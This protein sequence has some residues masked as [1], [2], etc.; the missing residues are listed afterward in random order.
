MLTDEILSAYAT[1]T[2]PEK[3]ALLSYLRGL[4]EFHEAG[5]EYLKSLDDKPLA[6][7]QKIDRRLSIQRN[8]AD[9][10]PKHCR[11]IA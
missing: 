11:R 5:S 6:Q 9:D 1:L 10:R 4:A 8:H 2:V 3:E 7:M